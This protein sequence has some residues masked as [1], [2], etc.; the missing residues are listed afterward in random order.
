MREAVLR[1]FF[2]GNVDAADLAKDI[3]G[4]LEQSRDVERLFIIDMECD[5]LVKPRHLVKVCDA[6][7]KGELNE[8]DVKSIGF[9]LLAS[10]AFEIRG[11][12]DEGA[13]VA[14]VANNWAVP[15]INLPVTRETIL[16][17]R[18]LLDSTS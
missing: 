9:T 13:K 8:R 15:E 16:R 17:W 10:D 2:E 3:S 7:L 11:N 1:D 14:E 4:S 12:T 5:F 18:L 6:Y